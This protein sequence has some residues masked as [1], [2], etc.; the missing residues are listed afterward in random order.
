MASPSPWWA[1]CR[2]CLKGILY[3]RQVNGQCTRPIAKQF[4]VDMFTEKNL[5]TTT[6]AILKYLSGGVI[7]RYQVRFACLSRIV[8][9]YGDRGAGSHCAGASRLTR[10]GG[11]PCKGEEPF[12]RGDLD[13][14]G[15]REPARLYSILTFPYL[16][17]GMET[18]GQ[19]GVDRLRQNLSARRAD[20]ESA[21]REGRRDRHAPWAMMI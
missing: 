3:W 20:Q 7:S 5:P 2:S 14:F 9:Y 17:S 1:C 8:D 19:A 10:T 4:R 12:S 15:M 16:P 6:D 21:L 18:L 11:Y 13:Q